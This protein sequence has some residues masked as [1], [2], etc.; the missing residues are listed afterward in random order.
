LS[1]AKQQAKVSKD[2]QATLK[3]TIKEQ[4]NELKDLKKERE[5]FR[6]WR[7]THKDEDLSMEMDKAQTMVNSKAKKLVMTGLIMRFK[8]EV[9]S[10]PN[11][12]SCR[13]SIAKIKTD[14]IAK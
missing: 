11:K 8:S 5:Q 6:K 9:L 7:H 3:K 12:E 10:R 4:S 13:R 2:A 14:Y 1:Q